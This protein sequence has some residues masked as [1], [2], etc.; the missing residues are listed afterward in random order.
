M[1]RFQMSWSRFK[2]SLA[3]SGGSA[4]ALTHVGVLRE[5]DRHGLRA[6]IIVGSS[7]GAVVGGLFAHYGN[8]DLVGERLRVLIE[9]D[10]FRK[11]IAVARDEPSG[12]GSETIFHRFKQLFRKGLSY[13]QS[14]RRPSLISEEDYRGIM[15]D[16]M[17]DLLIEDLPVRF[18]AVAMDVLSGEE[19]II[20]KG[21]LRTAVAAS[22][23][24]PGL[25]P[26]IEYRGR[27]LV[28]GGWLDNVPVAPAIALGG[29]FVL[30]ADASVDVAGLGPLPSSAVE[31]LSLIHI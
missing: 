9:S 29:H 23:A 17:P 1:G 2:F 7:M 28:D 20:T 11:A 31:Y 21:S 24:I 26:P 27:L 12:E 19:V 3:L 4:R 16:L 6:D 30:A 8:T 15:E 14:M 22:S 13:G 25:L 18:A 10:L 5:I